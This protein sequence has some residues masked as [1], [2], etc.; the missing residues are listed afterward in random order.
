MISE[1]SPGLSS[2]LGVSSQNIKKTILTSFEV[3]Y[4]TISQ[5]QKG[6]MDCGGKTPLKR[7]LSFES[8]NISE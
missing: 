7:E 2:L 4:F 3:T 5:I 8:G 1:I 6:K